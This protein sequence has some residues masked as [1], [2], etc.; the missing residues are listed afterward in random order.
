MALAEAG[1]DVVVI[2]TAHGHSIQVSRVVERIKR[3]SRNLR[4][5]LIESLADPLTGAIRTIPYD[6]LMDFVGRPGLLTRDDVRNKPYI[7]GMRN[8]H[9]VGSTANEVYAR[10]LEAM[11]QAE[12]DLQPYAWLFTSTEYGILYMTMLGAPWLVA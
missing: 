11:I 9:I 1:V 5:T 6:L 3:D 8:R 7:V 2:D 10:G 4:G 12:I